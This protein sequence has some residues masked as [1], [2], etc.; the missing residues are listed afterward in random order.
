[1]CNLQTKRDKMAK[2]LN[3]LVLGSGGV[4]KTAFINR[5][6][7]TNFERLYIPTQG[8]VATN[9]NYNNVVF[10]LVEFAGQEQYG[11][12]QYLDA[13]AIILMFDYTSNLSYKNLQYWYDNKCS[14]KHIPIVIVANK[15]DVQ[16]IGQNKP[17]KPMPF[18]QENFR[19]FEISAKNNTNVTN[20]MDYLYEQM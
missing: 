19:Y 14:A 6:N 16:Y 9:V 4:G 7:N 1:M 12:A 15:I 3:I 8:Q 11:K 13:D 5:L 17:K 2:V 18:E 10:N 20:V